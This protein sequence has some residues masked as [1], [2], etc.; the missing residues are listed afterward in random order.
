M[1]FGLREMKILFLIVCLSI[2]ACQHLS[3]A[4]EQNDLSAKSAFAGV[5]LPS[6]V[7]EAK[8]K[9]KRSAKEKKKGRKQKQKKA[10]KSR[11][12]KPKMGRKNSKQKFGRRSNQKK[13]K[14]TRKK[15]KK[16]KKKK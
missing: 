11:N 5:D 6:K 4:S 15:K 12:S 13:N 1:G 7:L 3:Q 9:V 14:K 16:K 8:Q 10:K 2:L